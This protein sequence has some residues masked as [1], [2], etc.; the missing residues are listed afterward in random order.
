ME[1][2]IAAITSYAVNDKCVYIDKDSGLI[3]E[4]CAVVI[5][6][7]KDGDTNLMYTD[8]KGELY[9]GNIVSDTASDKFVFL[10]HLEDSVTPKDLREA[11]MPSRENYNMG[12]KD[13]L[14]SASKYMLVDTSEAEDIVKLRINVENGVHNAKIVANSE[15]FEFGDWT[16][17]LKDE[18]FGSGKTN[19]LSLQEGLVDALRDYEDC[20]NKKLSVDIDFE[21]DDLIVDDEV[22][23][24]LRE[25]FLEKVREFI[26]TR[27]GNS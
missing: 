24:L 1:K 2:N 20:L 23:N 19:G 26:S 11:I 14:I 22:L 5:S 15:F 27:K 12:I 7:D 25:K 21:G 6:V 10:G 8:V 16:F 17:D 9:G 18:N 3:F 13:I 4:R